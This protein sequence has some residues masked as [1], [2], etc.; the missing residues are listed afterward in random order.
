MSLLLRI[1]SEGNL[2]FK[3]NVIDL[4]QIV[5]R[6]SGGSL[7]DVQ[8]NVIDISAMLGNNYN[9]GNLAN[10]T[11][12]KALTANN[13]DKLAGQLPDYYL[14]KG[15]YKNTI[16]VTTT[17]VI[18]SISGVVSQTSA[19]LNISNFD[20]KANYVIAVNKGAIST[21]SSTG[22]FTYTAPHITSA[23]TDTVV[24]FATKAGEIRSSTQAVKIPLFPLNIVAAAA[25]I[26]ADFKTNSAIDIGFQY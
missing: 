3:N 6:E 12:A 15:N 7:Q 16:P 8:G 14:S 1:D 5:I 9:T 18:S 22:T 25:L 2:R 24:I 4:S 13:A 23:T 21:V 26:N 20:S 19:T 10:T 17:P 11:V